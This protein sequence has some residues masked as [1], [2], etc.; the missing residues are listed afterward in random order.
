M[1]SLPGNM[2]IDE[3]HVEKVLLERLPADVQTMLASGSQG[4]LVPQ[5]AEMAGRMI[6]VRVSN[7]SPSSMLTVNDHMMKQVLTMTNKMASLKQQHVRPNSLHPVSRRRSRSRPRT[8]DACWYHTNIVQ[9]YRFLLPGAPSLKSEHYRPWFRS[10]EAQHVVVQHLHT[11]GA[12]AFAQP[13]RLAPARLQ[14]SEAELGA[15]LQMGIIQ[16]GH[17]PAHGV[18]GESRWLETV[19]RQPC[20]QQPHHPRS[21]SAAPT[22]IPKTVVTIPFRLFELIRMSFSLLSAA[23]TFQRFIDNALCGLRFVYAH[24]DYLLVASIPDVTVQNT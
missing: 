24:F 7:C 4:F 14:T 16:P 20:L 5:L 10:G 9:R 22:D 21:I 17:P 23:Q 13:G 6:E 12:P 2:L 8:A 1:R 18:Q 19:W 3:K 11:S 15:M